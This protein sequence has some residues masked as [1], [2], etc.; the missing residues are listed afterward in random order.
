MSLSSS[1]FPRESF[2][3]LAP[4]E[5]L[6]SDDVKRVISLDDLIKLPHDDSL[7]QF[8]IGEYKPAIVTNDLFSFFRFNEQKTYLIFIDKRSESDADLRRYNFFGLVGTFG[9]G[10]IVASSS[11]QTKK[12]LNLTNVL[13]NH[14]QAFVLE[15]C[16]LYEDYD[17][18][19]DWWMRDVIYEVITAS[20]QDSN[21]DGFG[22]IQGLRQ[23][24]DY[25]QSIGIKTIWLTPIYPSPWKDYGYDISNFCDI[26]PRFG[27]L[28]D[29]CQLVA[30]VHS[31][32]MRLILDFVP[33]HTSNEHT[34]FQ[35]ALR[36]D[37]NYVDYYVWHEGKNNG[38]DLPN[39]WLG[40]SGQRMWTYAP[41]RKMYYLHQFLDCQPDLNLRNDKVLEELK[42]I[43]RF[44]LDL[45]VDGFRADAV[46]HLIENDDFRDEPLSKKAKDIDPNIFYDAYE[47][48]ET[49]DQ[50]ESYALVRQWRR[51]LDNYSY[52]NCRDYLLFVTEAYHQD[53]QKVMNYYGANREERGS[54]VSINFLITYY[55]DKNDNEQ[56]GL[57]LDKQLT[58]WQK[59]V[60]RHAWSN[61]CLGSHDSGRVTSRLPSTELI[62]GF[63]MLL[64]LQSGTALLYYGDE[65]AMCNRP[66]TLE[67]PEE[68][69]DITAFNY[70]EKYVEERTRDCQRTPMQWTSHS[71]YA[72][73]TSATAK[74]YLPLADTWPEL[75]VEQ[76]EKAERSHLKLFRQ[77][78]KLRQQS[79]FYGGH[80]KKVLATKELYAFIRWLHSDIYLI[81][82]NQTTSGHEP[83]TTDFVKLLKYQNKQLFGE[84]V[85]K[86]T[87]ISDTSPIGK[88]GNRIELNQ[89][90]LQSNESLV[91]RLLSSVLEISLCIDNDE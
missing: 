71:P 8:S 67:H 29:F 12:S 84:V 6:H 82:I 42:R 30:D 3:L 50:P 56:H 52:D 19:Q 70:G 76:Q 25:I 41:E 87:N 31:R 66:F 38:K 88:E 79:P 4:L 86:S 28:D 62:D 49:A 44:W 10:K 85:A 26:D 75:N 89:L 5:S 39:N 2:F 48:T 20:Y 35:A 81:V 74:P 43:L 16:E 46:R 17:E 60:P 14:G 63:Y 65:I 22:D 21:N 58:K 77:L 23:R 73:F 57:E 33:N 32:N 9:K 80:Q 40:P 36:N 53:I 15:L 11:K 24:L 61:W 37:P 59:N 83:I 91:L 54:D 78:V 27:T 7:A 45:G 18:S 47:H 69:V 34:W 1:V 72:G 90:T 64:L 55:L 51:F 13:S 68:I